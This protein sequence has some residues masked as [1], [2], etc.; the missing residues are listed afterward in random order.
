M[1]FYIQTSFF[2]YFQ[3]QLR[4]HRCSIGISNGFK[5]NKKKV[6][7][8]VQK[9]GLQVKSYTRKSRKYSSYKVVVGRIERNR[10][11]RR[12]NTNIVHQKIT[13]DTTGLKYY[14]FDAN[15]KII[16]KKMYLD[17]FLD[18]FNGEFLSYSITKSPSAEGIMK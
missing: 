2:H 6:Q 9:L 3:C 8:L 17:P 10:V 13:T 5:S 11:N 12:F 1:Y 16:T 7:R 18:M 4:G 15:G 14:E